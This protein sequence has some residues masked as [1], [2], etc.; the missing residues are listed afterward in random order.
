MNVW[1]K[2]VPTLLLI[3]A[4]AVSF[5]AYGQ[6]KGKDGK[7]KKD[8]KAKGGEKVELT[9]KAFEGKEPFYQEMN[10][11][12]S[13]HMTVMGMKHQQE[14]NQTFYFS[15]TPDPAKSKD[16]KYVVT[17]KILGIKMN[18]DIGGNKIAY[19]SLDKEQ[20]KNPMSE[21]FKA[22][23]GAE[24]TITIGKDKEGKLNVEKVEGVSALVNKLKAV[25]PQMEG[26]LNEILTD[27]SIK[28][29]AQP[30]LNV[31]PPRPV[32]PKDSWESSD[33]LAMG[34]IG[35]YVTKNKYTYEGPAEGKGMAQIKVETSL[36]YQTP[37]DT[38]KGLPFKILPGSTLKSK[39]SVGTVLFNTAAGRV[40]SADMNVKLEGTLKI[41]IANMETTV[42]LN[43]T[44][45]TKLK[46]MDKNPIAK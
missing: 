33:K 14:Q 32:A 10:T 34:P 17:Q 4:L 23:I 31:V 13:Q 30:M 19:N 1:R 37:A 21:F 39:D 9:F 45:V 16:G 20:P 12:T 5:T 22:L 27:D 40:E 2:L 11:V 6:E 29:M 3:A 41:E 18:I 26:L 25:N 46:T 36:D 42:E 7:D 43:Q 38:K 44:Q 35:T 24:F 28:Q 8:D 15:W